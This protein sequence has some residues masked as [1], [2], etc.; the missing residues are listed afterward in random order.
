MEVVA[1]C[2]FFQW[3]TGL[4]SETM[5]DRAKITTPIGDSQNTY[6]QVL[7]ER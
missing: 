5:R 4:I 3:K 1:K 7:M 6:G 2:A